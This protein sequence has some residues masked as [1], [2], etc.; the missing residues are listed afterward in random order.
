MMRAQEIFGVIPVY[1]DLCPQDTRVIPVYADLC[2]Q[3]TR[4]IPVY[5]DLCLQDTRVI[6]VYADLCLQE[7]FGTRE[8]F[9]CM[10][11][12]AQDICIAATTQPLM[13][14]V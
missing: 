4:V 11:T 3:D 5:A 6:P 12:C 14:Q 9:L 13:I 10:Q 8:L 7:T 1:A 2:L